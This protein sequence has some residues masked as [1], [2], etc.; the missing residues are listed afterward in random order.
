[1]SML[2][3]LPHYTDATETETTTDS[4]RAVRFNAV[5][6]GIL[7]RHT[8]LPHEDGEEYQALHAALVAEHQPSGP[9]EAHL[10]EELAGIIWRKRRVLQAEGARINEDLNNAVRRPDDVLPAA[11]PFDSSLSGQEIDLQNLLTM[12]P[13]LVEDHL[14]YTRDDLEA[15]RRALAILEDGDGDAYDRAV[16][17]LLADSREWWLEHIED[18]ELEPTAEALADFIR[19]QLEPACVRGYAAMRHHAAIKAQ[20]LGK[21]LQAYRLEKLSRYET[22][23]DRKFQRTLGM[24]VKL[25]ELRGPGDAV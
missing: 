3:N 4:Y 14:E 11:A 8:V 15:C 1:M 5:K 12:T 6:H 19:R 7:S 20:A 16:A 24:L 18:E 2:D 10:V 23:L 13:E 25:R 21:G 22:H 9:T 17:T